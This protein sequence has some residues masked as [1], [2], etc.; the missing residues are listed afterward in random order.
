M[1]ILARGGQTY[2]RLRC[3]AGPGGTLILPVEIDFRRPFAAADWAAWDAEYAQSVVVE[4]AGPSRRQ[5]RAESAGPD[6]SERPPNRLWDQ[7]FW[8]DE[9]VGTGPFDDEL[10]AYTFPETLDEQFGSPF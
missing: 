2:A 9:L 7:L 3:S 8:G 6:Q 4:S 5:R 10:P 1:F